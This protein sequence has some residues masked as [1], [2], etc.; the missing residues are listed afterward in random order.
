MSTKITVENNISKDAAVVSTVDPQASLIYD[1]THMRTLTQKM[2]FDTDKEHIVLLSIPYSVHHPS[3]GLGVFRVQR[4][5]RRNGL[6]VS[7]IR[8]CDG[9]CEQLQATLASL[10][11]AMTY[12]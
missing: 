2:S 7:R 1:A 4:E 5:W 12:E 9:D 6:H 11:K 3:V 10:D 8:A